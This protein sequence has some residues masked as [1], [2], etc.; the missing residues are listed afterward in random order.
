MMAAADFQQQE[1]DFCAEFERELKT[2]LDKYRATYPSSP[3]IVEAII[4]S[5]CGGDPKRIRPLVVYAVARYFGGEAKSIMPI[6]MAI[7]IIHCYSL[8]HD[9]LPAM[10]DD[11]MR[12]GMPSC[13]KKFGEAT[14]ILTGDIMQIIAFESVFA[15]EQYTVATK[16][17]IL[18]QLIQTS[19]DIVCGQAMDLRGEKELLS[20]QELETM[21]KLKCGALFKAAFVLGALSQDG[22]TEEQLAKIT[23]IGDKVGL[24]FQ[25]RDDILDDDIEGDSQEKHKSTFPRILGLQESHQELRKLR[26]EALALMQ[27]FSADADFLRYLINNITEVAN[28]DA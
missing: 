27:D 22:V 24:A 19:R 25:I 12:R 2:F 5:A 3:E 7:E 9:D 16:H 20:P 15:S 28:A 4:Y 21:H 10:D 18:E 11:D 26:E 6:A 14:A 13:H 17:R 23:E 8:I 1:K